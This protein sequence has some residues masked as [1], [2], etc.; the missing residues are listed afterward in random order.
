MTQSEINI[1]LE[2]EYREMRSLGCKHDVEKIAYRGKTNT[3]KFTACK[4]ADNK[5]LMGW[6]QFVMLHLFDQFLGIKFNYQIVH[7][8]K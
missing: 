4:H 5:N 6:V 7:S 3:I 2:N 8:I 1:F